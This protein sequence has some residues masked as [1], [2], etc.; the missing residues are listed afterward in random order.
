[1]KSLFKRIAIAIASQALGYV[2]WVTHFKIPRFQDFWGIRSC[3]ESE[4]QRVGESRSLHYILL[5]AFGL[6]L[7]DNLQKQVETL[8]SH[9]KC[10]I[11]PIEQF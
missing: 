8:K 11:K 7:R 10:L 4:S 2:S 5:L 3:H 9:K 6:V 1:M